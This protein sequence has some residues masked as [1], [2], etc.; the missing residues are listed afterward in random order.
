MQ[1][2]IDASSF[3]IYRNSQFSRIYYTYMFINYQFLLSNQKNV[4]LKIRI[5]TG[6][7]V[8]FCRDRL[9]EPH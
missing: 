4:E 7:S 9:N 6:I 3:T 1:P 8:L 2:C 5:H